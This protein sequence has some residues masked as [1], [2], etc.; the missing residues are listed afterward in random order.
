MPTWQ[1]ILER[2]A[3][4]LAVVAVA[5]VVAFIVRRNRKK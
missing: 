4:S 3:F 1:E 2:A 5:F